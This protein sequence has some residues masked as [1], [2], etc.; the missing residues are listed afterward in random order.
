MRIETTGR[1]ELIRWILSWTPDVKVLAP[2]E[3]RTRIE[4][5]LRQGLETAI[6]SCPPEGL[7]VLGQPQSFVLVAKVGGQ[8]EKRLAS[9]ARFPQHCP[10]VSGRVPF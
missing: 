5:K 7:E 1:K 10:M 3:V 8:P 4:E 2:H 9:A 6:F